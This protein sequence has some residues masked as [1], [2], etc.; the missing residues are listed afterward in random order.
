MIAS[1]PTLIPFTKAA[2]D[3]LLTESKRLTEELVAVKERVKAAREMG[4][5]SENGAYHYGKFELGSISR[6]LRTIHHQLTQGFI[7]S[8]PTDNTRVHI[9]HS[10]VVKHGEKQLTF[11]LVSQ[12]EADPQAGKISTDSPLGKAILGKKCGD[13]AKVETPMGT[14]EYTIEKIAYT[15]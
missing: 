12:Y 14:K 7:L 4:D 2:Y 6:Q 10:V 15:L 13:T 8:K 1:K 11:T 3:K 5:L 9:G